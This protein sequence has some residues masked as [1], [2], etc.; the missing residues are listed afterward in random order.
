MK[1]MSGGH[2]DLSKRLRKLFPELQA[3]DRELKADQVR[4]DKA[5]L[6]EFRQI[7]DNLRMTAWTVSELM[8]ARETDKNPEPL[9]SF[10][11]SER[12]R[13]LSSMIRDLCA[14]MDNQVFAGQSSGVNALSEAVLGLQT[15]ITQLAADH[16]PEVHGMRKKA[17]GS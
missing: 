12:M 4:P 3:I 5:A 15:R 9:L 7:L 13:R 14:D 1:W 17:G 6:Q 2:P 10:L 16:Q 11:A 8:N